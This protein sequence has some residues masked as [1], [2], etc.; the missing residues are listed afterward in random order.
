MK[1]RDSEAGG[2]IYPDRVRGESIDPTLDT[3]NSCLGVSTTTTISF[4]EIEGLARV[5][6]TTR[7]CPDPGQYDEGGEI[8]CPWYGRDGQRQGV[9]RYL[10]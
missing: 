7:V 8:S 6:G 4:T 10:Q 2:P 3:S 1:W 5:K 9:R